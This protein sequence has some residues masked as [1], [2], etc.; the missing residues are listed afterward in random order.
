MRTRNRLLTMG[1]TIV[2]LAAGCGSSDDVATPD[3][4]SE[5][6]TIVLAKLPPNILLNWVN[7]TG[8]EGPDEAGWAARLTRACGQPV[9]EGDNAETLAAEFLEEDG[10]DPTSPSNARAA[11]QAL[12]VMAIN[13]CRDDAPQEAIDQGP[14]GL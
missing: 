10:G 8:L 2:A 5:S 14:P 6:T 11:A 13:Y 4:A 1:L 7:Q 3:P 9:W 12:W